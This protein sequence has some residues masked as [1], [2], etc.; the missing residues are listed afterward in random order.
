[1]QLPSSAILLR[2]PC[3]LITHDYININGSKVQSKLA[4][5]LLKIQKDTIITLSLTHSGA[6]ML[7]IGEKFMEEIANGLPHHVYVIFDLYGRCER[8][9]L[10]PSDMRSSSPVNEEIMTS[11][12]VND[13][14]RNVPQLEKA[15]LEVHEKETESVVLQLDSD[16]GSICGSVSAPMYVNDKNESIDVCRNGFFMNY[17]LANFRTRSVAES[18]SE[19]LLHNIS[20]K[21]RSLDNQ[22]ASSSPWLVF[23][24]GRCKLNSFKNSFSLLSPLSVSSETHCSCSIRPI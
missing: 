14:D 16:G 11:I 3:W 20:I 17:F 4:E 19:N 2:R 8:I 6:L 7:Q 18:V 13:S 22:A 24:H 15:D 9:S 23:R 1:M 10:L 12:T 5:A 21:N